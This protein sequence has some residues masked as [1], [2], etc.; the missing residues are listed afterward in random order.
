MEE[1]VSP[2]IMGHH[3]TK[4]RQPTIQDLESDAG[5]MDNLSCKP[6]NLRIVPTRDSDPSN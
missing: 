4:S 3:F 5:I 1:T 6:Q 2:M